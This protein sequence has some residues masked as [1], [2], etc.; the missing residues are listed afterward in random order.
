VGWKGGGPGVLLFVVVVG[1]RRRC[2][3]S[4]D[5]DASCAQK[6]STVGR[7]PFFR[8]KSDR[9]TRPPPSPLS[10]KQSRNQPRKHNTHKQATRRRASSSSIRHARIST[11]THR[12]SKNAPIKQRSS[13]PSLTLRAAPLAP[14]RD[15]RVALSA[16]ISGLHAPER[17][18]RGAQQRPETRASAHEGEEREQ[19]EPSPPF[20]LNNKHSPPRRARV[21]HRAPRLRVGARASL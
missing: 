7:P 11:C 2:A 16:P 15:R 8:C 18:G 20:S 19:R 5:R 12:F 10:H 3:K 13:P 21:L 14:P 9:R 17:G 6:P 1:R 4:R